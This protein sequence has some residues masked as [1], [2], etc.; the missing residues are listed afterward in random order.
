MQRTLIS[1]DTMSGQNLQFTVDREKM[2]VTT[3]GV[4]FER[5]DKPKAIM[6]VP[7]NNIKVIHMEDLEEEEDGNE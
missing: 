6:I 7:W 4:M 5:P 3:F 2:D 1:I